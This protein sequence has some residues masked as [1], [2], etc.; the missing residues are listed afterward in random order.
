[1]SRKPNDIKTVPLRLSTTEAI[2][3][4]LERL[5]ST[6]L[7][8]KNPAEAAEQLIARGIARAFLEAAEVAESS[9]RLI[10]TG[11][12]GRPRG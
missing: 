4:H 7:Y 9:K 5:V 12:E 6:G 2:R 1:M 3:K 10:E 8:G 11:T